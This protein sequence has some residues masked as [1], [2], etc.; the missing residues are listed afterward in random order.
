MHATDWLLFTPEN[1]RAWE[2]YPELEVRVRR[3]AQELDSKADPEQLAHALRAQFATGRSDL[4]AMGVLAPMQYLPDYELVGHLLVQRENYYGH[5]SM[6]ALQWDM[7][8]GFALTREARRQAVMTLKAL[9]RAAGASTL[10]ALCPDDRV[11]RA[12][13]LF[14]GM[15][16]FATMMTLDLEEA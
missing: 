7:D 4:W 16:R 11:A 13:R 9:C 2:L 15:G 6:L 8:E 14:L 12:H 3:F 5:V 1:T 10:V